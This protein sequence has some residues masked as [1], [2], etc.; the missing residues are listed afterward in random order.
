MESPRRSLPRND[1]RTGMIAVFMR[2]IYQWR[3]KAPRSY[4]IGNGDWRRRGRLQN[5]TV[6]VFG[7][8]QWLG[9][10]LIGVGICLTR[11]KHEQVNTN[12][13]LS[14]NRQLSQRCSCATSQQQTSPIA[15]NYPLNEQWAP[16]AVNS[17]KAPLR[18]K[19][20]DQ[21]KLARKAPKTN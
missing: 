5:T 13:V 12:L 14:F 17:T 4:T 15:S 18:R 3:V 16:L 7:L 9:R 20:R 6:M 1:A 2:F 10:E 21:P 8:L 11:L 19:Q